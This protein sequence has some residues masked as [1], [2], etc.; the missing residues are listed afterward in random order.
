MLEDRIK[1]LDE[2]RKKAMEDPLF[3]ANAAEHEKAIYEVEDRSET[4]KPP[5]KSKS[6]A[7][8]YSNREPAGY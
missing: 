1:R 3:R 8:I 7:V 5:K 2:L 6:F 4:P